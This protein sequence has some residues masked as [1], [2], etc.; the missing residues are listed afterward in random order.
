MR[1][2]REAQAHRAVG[3][4]F[5]FKFAAGALVNEPHDAWSEA[6]RSGSTEE[7]AAIAF[8]IFLR[9]TDSFVAKAENVMSAFLPAVQHS[10]S[11]TLKTR[12]LPAGAENHRARVR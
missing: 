2:K 6:A 8:Q 9:Q 7:T 12:F 4:R 10:N 5:A 1:R 3:P 11:S